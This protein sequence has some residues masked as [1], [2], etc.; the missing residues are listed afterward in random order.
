MQRKE[1]AAQK[2]IRIRAVCD[3]RLAAADEIELLRGQMNAMRENRPL[4]EKTVAIVDIG[5]LGF[6]K[7]LVHPA[8]LRRVLGNVGMHIGITEL[9]LQIAGAGEEFGRRRR[10]EPW[11]DRIPQK[12]ALMPLLQQLATGLIRPC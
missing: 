11:C 9:A 3:A 6:M 2:Q 1:S 12:T 5:V 4:I 7:Q 10:R 8:N